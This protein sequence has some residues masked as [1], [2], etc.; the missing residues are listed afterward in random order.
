[1]SPR[2]SA[3][4]TKV[5]MQDSMDL[6]EMKE[7]E[8]K[9]ATEFVIGTDPEVESEKGSVD[10]EVFEAPQQV[11]KKKVAAKSVAAGGAASS[12][13][14]PLLQETAEK[15]NLK[16]GEEL[17][18]RLELE[19]SEKEIQEMKSLRKR[20]DDNETEM[21]RFREEAARDREIEREV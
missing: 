6:L 2:L 5:E 18:K 14:W 7:E 8:G 20:L 4:E 3:L 11:K 12:V 19:R 17:R 1:M 9:K 13:E 10:G 15:L 16:T 21:K